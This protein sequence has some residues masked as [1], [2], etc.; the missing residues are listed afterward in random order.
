MFVTYK[1]TAAGQ[2][3]LDHRSRGLRPE[4]RRLL[5]L[6]DGKRSVPVLTP[7]FRVGE[8]EPLIDE[9]ISFDMIEAT[10][11]STAFLPAPSETAEEVRTPLSDYRLAA[12][13]VAA[14]LGVKEML[15]R[16]AKKFLAKLDAC[17]DSKALRLVVSEIQLRLISEIGDD[18]ATAFVIRIRDAG[19]QY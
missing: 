13:L 8:I 10:P 4:L 12:A 15:A 7:L 6:V 11:T 19:R 5:I 18:A 3:E 16:D 2:D 9:L 1:K 17:T 14:R